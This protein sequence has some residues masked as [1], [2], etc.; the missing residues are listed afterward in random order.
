MWGEGQR[1][2]IVT[3]TL[4]YVPSPLAGLDTDARGHRF[5]YAFTKIITYFYS[6]VK[7]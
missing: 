1:W 7:P 5:R 3:A 2:H 6:F 4:L